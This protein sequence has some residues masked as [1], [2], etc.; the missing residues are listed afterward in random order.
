M[1]TKG[2]EMQKELEELILRNGKFYNQTGKQ[3]RKRVV[4][5]GVD[6]ASAANMAGNRNNIF[7]KPI[8]QGQEIPERAN[9]FIR[10]PIFDENAGAWNNFPRYVAP[11]V[12]LRVQK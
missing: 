9:A 12:Y 7:P 8:L 2:S 1:R 6:L 5:L 11:T 4:V 10:G 3:V